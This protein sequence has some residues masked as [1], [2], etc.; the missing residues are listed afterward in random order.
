MTNII[1]IIIADSFELDWQFR[2]KAKGRVVA[3]E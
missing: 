1:E 3:Q 2:Q